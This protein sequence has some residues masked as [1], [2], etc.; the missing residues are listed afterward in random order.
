MFK[1]SQP[2]KELE[3]MLSGE[4]TQQKIETLDWEDAFMLF[5]K[6]ESEEWPSEPL[7]FK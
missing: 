2:V 3:K 6:E 1:N 7:N 4:E 5:Y